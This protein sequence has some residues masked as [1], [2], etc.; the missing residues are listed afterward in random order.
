MTKIQSLKDRAPREIP[1]GAVFVL[2]YFDGVHLGHRALLG[3]AARL[4][5]SLS[6]PAAVWTLEKPESPGSC[7]TTA[8]EKCRLFLA[9]GADYAVSDP[10]EEIRGMEG[11]EFFS[12]LIADRFRPAA[13][14]CGYNFT[15]GRGASCR[16]D[17]LRRFAEARGIA[18]SVLDAV[19]ADGAPVSSTRIRALIARGE[20]EEAARL[21]GRPY[22][23]DAPVVKGMRLGHALGFP[24]VNQ[25]P[26]AEKLLPPRGVY[27]SLLRTQTGERYE[28]VSNLGSR[29]TVNDDGEDVTLETTL[30]GDPGD[31][32]GHKITTSLV[33][34]LRE[35][36][37][38]S[39]LD[40][41]EER[42]AK[43]AD[44]ARAYWKTMKTR[45]ESTPAAMPED[46]AGKE[47]EAF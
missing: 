32:Y 26:P 39:S 13:V 38:F 21:L 7:L 10:F 45:R 30:F 33:K 46:T 41:L 20:M 8:D 40:A 29:P 19:E 14:I 17:D 27:V 9:H 16:A 34:Y 4:G 22:F 31:L 5:A 1:P 23:V 2:G 18:V 28:G 47:E 24:T 35:E 42:I 15:F 43:D 3:E 44:G 36:M 12:S 25:R 37:R 6:A 11:E